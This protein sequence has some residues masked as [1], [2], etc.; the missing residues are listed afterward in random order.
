MDESPVDKDRMA[1]RLAELR[2]IFSKSLAPTRPLAAGT[3]LAPDMLAA[4]KP[5]TGIPATRLPEVI[6]RKLARDVSPER[7]L[8]W[9]DFAEGRDA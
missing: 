6:G 1:E 8:A 2:G 9:S 4:K 7:L 3:V 5:G